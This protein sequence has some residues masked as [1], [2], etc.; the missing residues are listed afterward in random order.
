MAISFPSSPSTG[1]VFTSGNRSWTWDGSA[2]KGGV[3]STGDA[4]TLDGLDSTD[5]LRTNGGDVAITGRLSVGLTTA[6]SLPYYSNKLV[7]TA[8]SQ[9]GITI[10]ANNTTATNYLMFADGTSGDARYRGY[11]EYN[12]NT[13]NLALAQAAIHRLNFDNTGAVFNEA[14]NDYDFRVESDTVTHALFVRGNDGNV[15]IGTNSPNARLDVNGNIA[16]SN[17]TSPPNVPTTYDQLYLGDRSQIYN[18]TGLGLSIS[19]NNEF[20]GSPIHKYQANGTAGLIEMFGNSFKYYNAP[21]GNAGQTPSWTNRFT[22]D[23]NG[24]VGIGTV[25]PGYKLSVDNGTSDGGI[26]KIH[27]EEVGLNVS[28][29][30]GVGDYTN[31]TRMVVFNA[32]RYD[33]GTSPKLRLG[34]QGGLEFAVDANNVRMVISSSGNVGIGTASPGKKLDVN[35][36]AR[37]T[38]GLTITP[39]ASSVYATDSTLSSYAT[40][41]G[42]YLNGHANG[43]LRLNGSGANRASIDVWGENYAAP[44]GDSITFRTGNTAERMMISASGNVGINTT[45]PDTNLHVFKAS[46]GTITNYTN[47]ALVVENSGDVGISLLTPNS[48]AGHLMFG[49]PGNQY[50]SYIRGGYGASTTSTL[51]FYTDGINTMTHKAGNVGIGTAN[52][53]S[54]LHVEGNAIIGNI[55]GYE[56]THPG[57]SGATLH[58]HNTATDGADTDGAVNFGDETQVIISTG[59]IDPGPQGYQGSLW[60]GTSDHPAGGGGLNAG[61]QWNWKVAGI[62]SKTTNDT[63][64]QNV[65]FGNLEFYTKGL[66]NTSAAALAM[67]I[68]ESQNVEINSGQLKLAN[69][70]SNPSAPVTGGMYFDTTSGVAY[71]YNG[72]GWDQISNVPMS[73]TGGTV[74]TY[75]SYKVHVFTSSGTFTVSGSGTVDYMIVAGGGGGGSLGGGGGAGGMVTGTASVQPGPYTITVGGGGTNGGPNNTGATG[76][77]SS[78]FSVTANGGGGGGSHSGGSNSTAGTSGGSGGGGSDNNNSFGPG[79]GTAGQGNQGGNGCPVFTNALRGGGGGG[80]KGNPGLHY[81]TLVNSK[82]GNGG[83]GAGNDLING[84]TQYFAGGGGRAGYGGSNNHAGDGGIG[85]GGGGSTSNG[86]GNGGTGGTGYNNGGNGA[87]NT[88]SAAGGNGGANT[89]GGAGCNSWS[90]SGGAAGGSGI[91]VVRYTV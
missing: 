5:F 15:G 57:E 20:G 72:T 36:E 74:S 67:T 38:T 89:G 23:A 59:A 70:S 78:A 30:G 88:T 49:S 83:A 19:T 46:A 27:N 69:L 4:T 85:G 41:N 6:Q 52:P 66:N 87:A 73:A 54:D 90:R 86:S 2:W 64:S 39:A 55:V 44:F 47:N 26:F 34:G 76:G 65:S 53:L 45:S 63:G 16:I 58:V 84:T 71:V 82:Y 61:T 62:A 13:E 91:V 7:L 32:T 10:A 50:H 8:S 1:Q 21:T 28:V 24:N 11:I 51:K 18:R 35:G 77:N 56:T 25:S 37:I 75:S 31:S 22:I 17:A 43:W 14:G 48:S 9:D 40:G 29:N 3:S 60:F 79:S 12:H 68:D 42:V 81:N 80:G 33:T